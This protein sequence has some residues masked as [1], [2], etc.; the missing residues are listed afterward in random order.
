LNWSWLTLRVVIAATLLLLLFLS[1]RF[2]YRSLW[3]WSAKWGSR[4]LRVAG[5]SGLPAGLLL[6]IVSLADSIRNGHGRLLPRG[7][8]LN[9]L[10]GLWFFS[11]LLRICRQNRSRTRPRMALCTPLSIGP[12]LRRGFGFACRSRAA[13]IS[14][15]PQLLPLARLR[16]SAPCTDLPPNV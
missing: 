4:V 11:A 14:S 6:I 5:A 3:R 7:T 8:F 15:K 16:S 10:A 2:W 1:Q 9:V 12:T 13:A